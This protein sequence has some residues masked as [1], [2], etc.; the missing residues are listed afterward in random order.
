MPKSGKLGPQDESAL[1]ISY[2]N[3][4]TQIQNLWTG[5]DK[6]AMI[7]ECGWEHTYYE[8]GMPE[9]LAMYHNVLWVSL[10]SGSCAT[11]FWWAY[12]PR[13]NESVLT[14]QMRCFAQFV[15]DVDFA[16]LTLEPAKIEAGPCDAWA[17]KSD[18][19]LFGWVVNPQ[20]SVAKESFTLSGLRDGPYTVRLYRTWCGSYL[21]R[22]TVVCRDGKLKVTIPE[23][24]TTGGRASNIGH[25]VAFKITPE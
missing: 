18:R 22:Q 12:S 10:A 6:P 25:D 20:T 3:Y 23:L 24:R 14:D 17:M 15:S 9:Y 11:P 2:K 21:E 19:L 8:P 7:G 4:A 5:F 1:R 16:N 13:L